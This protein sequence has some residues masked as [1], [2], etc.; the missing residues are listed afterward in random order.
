MSNEI[1]VEKRVYDKS[2]QIGDT[3]Y[4]LISFKELDTLTGRLMQM[5]ELNGD[6]EQREALKR[7]LKQ[8][9]K[10][11]LHGHYEDA[12]YNRWGVKVAPEVEPVVIK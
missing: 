11:W 4:M 7:T 5:C 3:V 12:G 6:A 9:T 10:D 1:A 2:V 8:I